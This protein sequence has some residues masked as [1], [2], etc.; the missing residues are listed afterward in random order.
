MDTGKLLN[1]ETT[2]IEEDGPVVSDFRE[3]Q[4]RLGKITKDCSFLSGG[5]SNHNYD[6]GDNRVLRVFKNPTYTST[7]DLE[8][9][10]NDLDW[11]NFCTAKTLERGPDYLVQRKLLFSELED[12]STHGSISGLTLGEI[13]NSKP[14]IAINHNKFLSSLYSTCPLSDFISK[15]LAWALSSKKTIS[16]PY[17][18]WISNTLLE[19]L[20][21]NSEQINSASEDKVLLHGD[22]KPSNI[23]KSKIDAGAV[24]FDWEFSFVGPRLV[25]IGHFLRWG[26]SDSFIDTFISSYRSITEVDISG[27]LLAAK[28]LDLVNL[29]FQLVKST[30]GSARENDILDHFETIVF[31]EANTNKPLR[32]TSIKP[33][34][35]E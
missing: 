17:R 3:V 22:C 26:A 33:Q 5:L 34:A 24:V 27:N 9:K 30:E 31:A 12:N 8:S 19:V 32:R 13:H 6:L 28:L 10:L 21:E 7:I 15:K 25:D 23:K 20:S 1:L 29:S 35:V 11:N 2:W 14:S 4:D 16:S 18:E